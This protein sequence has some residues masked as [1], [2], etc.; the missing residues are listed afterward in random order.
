VLPLPAVQVVHAVIPTRFPLIIVGKEFRFN[1]LK[2]GM[3]S[4]RS[5][6]C[7][8]IERPTPLVLY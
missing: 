8:P 1:E 4:I 7:N 6:I 2:A 3:P 5:K